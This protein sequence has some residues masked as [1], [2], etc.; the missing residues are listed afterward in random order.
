MA[1]LARRAGSTRFLPHPHTCQ[2]RQM[3]GSFGA[4]HPSVELTHYGRPPP[5]TN[6]RA[7]STVPIDRDGV[8]AVARVRRLDARRLTSSP[9]RFFLPKNADRRL[10]R[11]GSKCFG[12][13][14]SP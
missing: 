11:R 1:C 4:G 5:L 8:A 7:R 12:Q 14:G 6:A 13:G 9:L 2:S 3:G 10:A